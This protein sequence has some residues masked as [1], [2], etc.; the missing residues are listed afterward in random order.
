MNQVNRRLPRRAFSAPP[1][2]STRS[3]AGSISGG[4][5]LAST[6]RVSKTRTP[7]RHAQ[8]ALDIVEQFLSCSDPEAAVRHNLTD[9]Q[10]AQQARFAALPLSA[11]EDDWIQMRHGEILRLNEALHAAALNM[12]RSL[13]NIRS[14]LPPVQ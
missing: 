12:L 13:A 1:I 3:G 5:K 8:E 7:L 14:A 4:Q 11:R 6:A 2:H 9:A 10:A